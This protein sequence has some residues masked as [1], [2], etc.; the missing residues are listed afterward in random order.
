MLKGL[1]SN[2]AAVQL[3]TGGWACAGLHEDRQG[4]AAAGATLTA[5]ETVAT[6]SACQLLKMWPMPGWPAWAVATNLFTTHDGIQAQQLSRV[7]QMS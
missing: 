1:H 2:T 6:T 5:D 3:M 4:W 7:Q